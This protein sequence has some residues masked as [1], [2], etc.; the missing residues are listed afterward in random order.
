MNCDGLREVYAICSL[1][2]VWSEFTLLMQQELVNSA[3]G[4]AERARN[5]KGATVL[6]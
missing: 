1:V 3:F 6:L 5:G 4:V 2:I